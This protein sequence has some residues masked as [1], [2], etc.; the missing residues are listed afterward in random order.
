VADPGDRNWERFEQV[1]VK[2][3]VGQLWQV[4]VI[5]ICR[6]SLCYSRMYKSTYY[7]LEETR[8]YEK[9]IHMKRPWIS[10]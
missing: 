10:F 2:V 8:L 9:T 7:V 4:D 1:S 3:K 6:K 5:Y